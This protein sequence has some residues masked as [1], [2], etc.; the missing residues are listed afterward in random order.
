MLRFVAFLTAAILAAVP[1]SASPSFDCTKARS[2][3]E[4]AICDVPNLQWT[5]RQMVRLYKLALNQNVKTRGA[6]VSGQRS[7]LS[8]RDACRDDADCIERAYKTRLAELA[9]DVSIYEAFGEYEPQGMGGSMWIVR[10]GHDAA[11]RIL[12]VGGGDHTCWF[13]TD[14]APVGGK[15]VIRYAEKG[16]NACRISIAPDGDAQ[17][18][19]TKNCNDYCGMRA[20][21]DGRYTR[22]P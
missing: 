17:V 10:F 2:A 19:Q 18:V 20:I 15:G 13:D 3:A 7:F 4:R 5:D 16:A 1:A 8:R 14:S 9:R 11:V 12:T 21:L 22:V 6:I